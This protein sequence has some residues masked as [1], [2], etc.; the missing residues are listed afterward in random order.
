MLTP[1][2]KERRQHT[3]V[4][5]WHAHLEPPRRLGA[6]SPR[7]RREG[8]EAVAHEREHIHVARAAASRW[9]WRRHSGGGA[10]GG[11]GG[12]TGR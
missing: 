2:D 8:A 5:L 6:R 10:G 9:S 4:D 3:D 11:T 1:P 7:A 12:G